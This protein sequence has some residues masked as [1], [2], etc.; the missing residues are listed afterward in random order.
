MSKGGRSYSDPSYGGHKLITIGNLT[1]ATTTQ[2]T[3]IVHASHQFMFPARLVQARLRFG[4]TTLASGVTDLTQA[5]EFQLF[6]STDSGTGLEA[7]LGT[8]DA[9]GATGTWL[10]T[11]PGLNGVDFDL[12]VTDFAVGDF[13]LFTAEYASDDPMQLDVELEIFENF[14]ES[15]N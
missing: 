6:K 12:T 15:D 5:T 2:G 11:D 3:N 10:I 7:V 8:A 9:L 14:V 13:V 4:G 1:G